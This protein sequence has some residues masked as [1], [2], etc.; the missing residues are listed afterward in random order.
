MD[1]T[2]TPNRPHYHSY[3]KQLR[4]LYQKPIAKTSSALILT[5]GTA[6][7]FGLA[8]IRPTLATVSQ[9][10]REIEDK[11]EIEE[12]LT[13]KVSALTS[14]QEEYFL[15][16][17]DLES[18]NTAIPPTQQIKLLLLQIE[19][20]SW[21]NQ[22][23]LENLRVDPIIIYAQ[24]PQPPETT[25]DAF[26]S[27]ILS[28]SVI[29]S[30]QHSFRGLLQSLDNLDRI[31]RIESVSFQRPQTDSESHRMTVTVRAY[32]SPPSTASANPA[33]PDTN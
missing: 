20:L 14:V 32:W 16:Q 25:I 10:M 23:P 17:N 2:L 7:F 6:A 5:L 1:T 9:L 27:F 4:A 33:N 11:K 31:V 30:D 12:Q 21:L 15:I 3:A 28:L 26:P 19:Y 13:K 29:S 22:T 8:A 24:N 18:L